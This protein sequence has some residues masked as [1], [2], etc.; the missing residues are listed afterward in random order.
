MTDYSIIP[1]QEYKL[2]VRLINY[3]RQD[4]SSILAYKNTGHAV[5]GCMRSVIGGSVRLLLNKNNNHAHY[6]GLLT[7][8]SVWDCPVCANKIAYRRSLEIRDAVNNW[9]DMGNSIMMITY[10]VRHNLGDTLNSLSDVMTN[11]IRFVHSGAPYQR[12]KNFYNIVGGISSTEVLFNP[13][14][15]WH[16]H[17]HQLVFVKGRL[18]S[19]KSLENWI[20]S[21]YTSYLNKLGY[22]SNKGIG[23]KITSNFDNNKIVAD[24][25][26]KW[27]VEKELTRNDNK[28]SIGFNPFEL[29]DNDKYH[30]RFIEYSITMQGRRKLTWSKGL[31]KLCGLV[32]I[33]FDDDLLAQESTFES[34]IE[35]HKFEYF[36]WKQII[37]FGLR[38]DILNWAELGTFISNYKYKSVG[39][40]EA[41]NGIKQDKYKELRENLIHL[42]D[43]G[44]CSAPPYLIGVLTKSG[45]FLNPNNLNP[46]IEFLAD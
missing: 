27:G 13:S 4:I 6:S 10:T 23:V 35:I 12:I 8:G 26:S 22:D 15:G 42:R 36:E 45:Y 14:T 3:K 11:A 18:K 29:L 40:T 19:Y 41:L 46:I 43:Y 24:Y 1:Q 7:C 9:S 38:A 44:I 31:R 30:S 20:Y 21:R 33:E 2:Q 39:V 17:K 16:Y 32:E 28:S 5:K 34:D 25:I 37:K